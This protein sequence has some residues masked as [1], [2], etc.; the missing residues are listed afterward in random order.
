[1]RYINLAFNKNKILE[2]HHDNKVIF[3][4]ILA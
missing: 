2:K 4:T 1:M 3:G